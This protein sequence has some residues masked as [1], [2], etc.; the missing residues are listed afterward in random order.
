MHTSVFIYSGVYTSVNKFEKKN[1]TQASTTIL[2]QKSFC[3]KTRSIRQLK[4]ACT[5]IHDFI[6]KIVTLKP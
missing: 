4:G 6:H 3:I 1:S 5:T 2:E